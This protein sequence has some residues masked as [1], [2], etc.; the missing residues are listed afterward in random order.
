MKN[1]EINTPLKINNTLK[2]VYVKFND[3]KKNDNQNTLI[4][5]QSGRGMSGIN[6]GVNNSV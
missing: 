1:D 3:T 6:E 5:A 4:V 2:K